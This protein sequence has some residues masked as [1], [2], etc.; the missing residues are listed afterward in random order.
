MLSICD[1][2]ALY[3]ILLWVSR[4]D[5][6]LKECAFSVW[7]CIPQL[8]I[9]VSFVVYVET[10]CSHPFCTTMYRRCASRYIALTAQGT[11]VI[12]NDS[13]VPVDFSWR[14]FPTVEEEIA[15][16]LKLQ[17]QLKQEETEEALFLQQARSAGQ[18][19]FD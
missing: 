16:K 9:R 10:Q 5:S 15:Q 12:Q 6:A 17:V 14:A 11:V 2:F 7:G 4:F 19:P 8:A 18:I 13:D 3:A 1:P